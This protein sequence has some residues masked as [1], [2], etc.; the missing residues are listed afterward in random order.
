MLLL[1]FKSFLIKKAFKMTTATMTETYFESG[2]L[3]N[4][5]KKAAKI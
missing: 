2:F 5:G 4:S 1:L 3:K